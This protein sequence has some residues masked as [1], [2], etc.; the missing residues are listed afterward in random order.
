MGFRDRIW[1][2]IKHELNQAQQ[3]ES[4]LRIRLSLDQLQPIHVPLRSTILDP[5]THLFTSKAARL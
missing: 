4:S 3:L 2:A 5:K 1:P